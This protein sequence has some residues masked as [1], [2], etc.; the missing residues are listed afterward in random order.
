MHV[1]VDDL[2]VPRAICNESLREIWSGY[3]YME[4]ILCVLR[5]LQYDCTTKIWTAGT[6]LCELN[7]HGYF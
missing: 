5:L 7:K 4:L 2:Y 3:E 1:H 6:H